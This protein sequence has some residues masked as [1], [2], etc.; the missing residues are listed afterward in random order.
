MISHRAILDVP[1]GLVHYLARLLAAERRGRRTAR[2]RRALS[3]FW[4]AVLVLRWFRDPTR[5]EALAREAGIGTA[6]AYRY[7]HEGID[8]L[9]AAAPDLPQVLDEARARGVPHLVLD[10]SLIATDRV[11]ARAQAGHD[12]WYSGKSRR[13]GGKV[14]FLTSPAG[15]P[16]W[17]SDTRPGSVHDL[18]AARELALP[19]LYPAQ[20]PVLADKGCTG[21]GVGVH[22]PI[23]KLPGGRQLDPDNRAYNALLTALRG[24]GERGMALLKTRW[25]ALRH[26]SL[27]PHR[28]GDI[29]RAALVLTHKQ[30]RRNY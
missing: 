8:A 24:L 11:A 22:V 30:H 26:V 13:H 25:Q 5:V 9:A 1:R 3:R 17:T 28:I 6:T 21:A 18:S 20:I 23:K 14:Q 15:F 27:D 29:V 16:L 7:L 12:L 2:R 4:Q 10:S 19:A